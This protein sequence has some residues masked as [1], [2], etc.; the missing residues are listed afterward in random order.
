MPYQHN[1]E[2]TVLHSVHIQLTFTKAVPGL[3]IRRLST[4]WQVNFP[5]SRAGSVIPKADSPLQF[6]SPFRL[7]LRPPH[8]FLILPLLL[9]SYNLCWQDTRVWVLDHDRALVHQRFSFSARLSQQPFLSCRR[10]PRTDHTSHASPINHH[11]KLGNLQRAL[12]L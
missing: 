7:R 9:L 5:V 4:H 11:C 6:L 12:F 3:P 1:G 8:I 10:L 2:C